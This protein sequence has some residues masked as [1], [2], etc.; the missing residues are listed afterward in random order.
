MKAQRK[1]P[2]SD[3]KSQGEKINSLEFNCTT[4]Y[5]AEIFTRCDKTD[6]I[7]I[8][9]HDSDER[10]IFVVGPPKDNAANGVRTQYILF[11]ASMKN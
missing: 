8:E 3:I 2:I 11:F 7:S 9:Y 1:V 10:P 4:P 6:K 5:I